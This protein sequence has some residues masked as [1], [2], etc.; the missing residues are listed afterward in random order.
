MANLAQFETPPA[1]IWGIGAFRR[2]PLPLAFEIFALG[3][4]RYLVAPSQI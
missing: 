2:Q 1:I 3:H 4:V